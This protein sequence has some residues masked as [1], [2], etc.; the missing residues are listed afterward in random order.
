[1]FSV[2]KTPTC[3][4]PINAKTMLTVGPELRQI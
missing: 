4:R 2:V 3:S 1:V